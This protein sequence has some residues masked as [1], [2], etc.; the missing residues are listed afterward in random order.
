MIQAKPSPL[1]L[2][3]FAILKSE[4][5]FNADQSDASCNL[6]EKTAQYPL[7]V[8]FGISKDDEDDLY[9][10][11]AKVLINHYEDKE[12]EPGYSIFVESAGFFT[13]NLDANLSDENKQGMLQYSAVS[14]CI[15]NM[16]LY[17]ANM[18]SFFPLGKYNF[19]AIDMNSL[20]SDKVKN[21]QVNTE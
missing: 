1:I 9:R 11:L 20:L 15:T 13:F 12:T 18:T 2:K 14:M 6:L 19:P 16:R 3:E 8:D 7:E 4:C 10:V 21:M 5:V 17:I